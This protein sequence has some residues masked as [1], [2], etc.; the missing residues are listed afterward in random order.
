LDQELA[1]EALND[2]VTIVRAPLTRTSSGWPG[3]EAAWYE[4][5]RLQ[6]AVVVESVDLLVIDG[7]PAYQ[8]GR[9]HSRYPAL[10]FFAPMLAKDHAVVLDDIDRPGE[11]DIMERWER[12]YGLEFERR[13]INGRVG[14]G[15]P[16]PAFTV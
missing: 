8:A 9:K 1:G 12:E 10:P 4:P 11:Q 3:E 15:R 14:I 5:S 7:P 16:G 6:Q 13:P 2:V